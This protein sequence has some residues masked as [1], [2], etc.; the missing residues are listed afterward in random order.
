M[1][2]SVTPLYVPFTQIVTILGDRIQFLEEEMESL[3]N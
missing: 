2:N 3:D 1:H